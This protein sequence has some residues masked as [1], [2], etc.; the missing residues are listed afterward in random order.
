[1][2]P[3]VWNVLCSYLFCDDAALLNEGSREGRRC[4]LLFSSKRMRSCLPLAI[5]HGAENN[6][7]AL[8]IFVDEFWVRRAMPLVIL[9]KGI[10]WRPQFPATA[11]PFWSDLDAFFSVGRYMQREAFG[12]W[13]AIPRGR[14]E[15]FVHVF[16]AHFFTKLTENELHDFEVSQRLV[17]DGLSP[18]RGI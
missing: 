17:V 1:M 6:S 2:W 7:D 14:R 12:K 4:C 18:F 5:L 10:L 15:D 16:T 9:T 8:A 13:K 3:A 11:G